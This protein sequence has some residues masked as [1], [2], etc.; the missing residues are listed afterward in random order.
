MLHFLIAF[1]AALTFAFLAI[2]SQT[3]S[4]RWQ[5]F[6]ADSD[7]NGP[8]KFHQ[9]AVP[10]IGGLAIFLSLTLVLIYG[11]FKQLIYTEVFLNLL[12]CALPVFLIGLLEDLSKKISPRLR[13]L[14]SMVS[15]GL[16]IY[17]L[18]A[19]INRTDT[20]FDH[21]FSNLNNIQ[22]IYGLFF[23]GLTIFAVAGLINAVNIIDGFNGLAGVISFVMSLSIAY[24]A[25]QNHDAIILL[26]AI[27]LAGALLG[28][29]FWNYPKG[30][31]FLG[32]GGAYLIGFL[33]AELVILL[34]YR[35][36]NI[37]AWYAILLFSYPIVETLFSIYRKK[38]LRGVSPT[39]PDGVHLHMLIYKRVLRG[40]P[41]L[42]NIPHQN[43]YPNN[44][45]ENINTNVNINIKKKQKFLIK[46]NAMTSPYL[47]L[48]SSLAVIPATLFAEHTL[49]LQGFFALFIISYWVFY[50]RIV[51][52]KT[53]K[54]I[55][56]HLK[57]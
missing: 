24:I 29:L 47:W 16:A 23:A 1:F 4:R 19:Y 49:I 39:I 20:F 18:Q 5:K 43:N 41:D 13:L 48:L 14:A 51:R 32:D 38:I 22:Q 57:K 40:L 35:H 12:I 54:K 10:R 56:K 2:I 33:L 53:P 34:V 9:T 46:K 30:F 52:F 55:I 6:A 15:A 31:I 27:S 45:K 3:W 50:W 11:Y 25:W 44:Y 7:L 36:Q 8:Q 21:V 42:S 37:S 26:I 28:F 17:F